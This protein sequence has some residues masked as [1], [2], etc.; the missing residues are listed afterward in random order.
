MYVVEILKDVKWKLRDLNHKKY[1]QYSEEK[2]VSELKKW[3]KKNLGKELDLN[4]PKSFNEKVQ[5]LKLYDSTPE[6]A[7]LADKLK[8][9]KWVEDKIGP[10]YLIPLIRM[11]GHTGGG[12]KRIDEI[13][14]FELPNSF[15][16][17]TNH[18]SSTNIIVK[19]KGKLNLKEARMKMNRWISSNYGFNQGFELHYGMIQPRVFCEKYMGENLNDYKFFCF[20]GKPDFIWV[21]VGRYT[22]HCRNIYDLEWNELPFIIGRFKRVAVDRPKT[23]ELMIKLAGEL[24]AGFSFVRVDFYEIEG[25]VYFGEMTFTSSSGREKFYPNE[26]DT[27]IGSRVRLPERNKIPMDKIIHNWKKNGEK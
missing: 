19:D 8:C 18:G 14:F 16:L 5:W 11:R 17:K 13:D 7:Y 20:D 15:V 12:A 1:Y 24:S 22:N 26:Y 9:R 3:Y 25:K 10:Q 23:L 6:K 27:I 4:N 21:D 2:L